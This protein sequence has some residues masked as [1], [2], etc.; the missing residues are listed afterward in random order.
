[1][2]TVSQSIENE[3]ED[4]VLNY[5][6]E[7][8]EIEKR[9]IRVLDA[10]EERAS[11]LEFKKLP[12]NS[13]QRKKKREELI[14]AN[15]RFVLFFVK[16]NF[17]AS[18]K[19]EFMDLVQA[20]NIGLIKAVDR[21]DPER[22]YKFVTFARD[23][24][25]N[26]VISYIGRAVNTIY[27]PERQRRFLSMFEKTKTEL[28]KKHEGPVFSLEIF[29]KMEEEVPKEELQ[30]ILDSQ[31]IVH[32]DKPVSPSDGQGG[33]TYGD[34][35]VDAESA[36]SGEDSFLKEDMHLAISAL[37]EEEPK[38]AEILEL[39]FGIHKERPYSLEEIGRM[40]GHTREAIRQVKEKALGRLRKALSGSPDIRALQEY[41]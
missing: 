21:F 31:H 39:F 12:R 14:L 41:K 16:E 1:M 24:V 3:E 19:I 30:K 17:W 7:I 13:P 40:Y 2:E 23:W 37:R 11:F 6:K 26:E 22:G 29:E 4:I 35:I 27:L 34:I 5:L 15:L 38:E 8:R 36:D 25:F 10:S 20:G 33:D 32:L 18:S 9:G 28:E